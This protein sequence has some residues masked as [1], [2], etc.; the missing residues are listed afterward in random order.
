MAT[1]IGSKALI[2]NPALNP[3]TV[4]IGEWQTTGSHPYLPDTLLHGRVACEWLL[5]GAF[6]LMRSEIDEAHFPDGIAIFGSD[7][8]AKQLFLLTFDQR[9]VSRKYDVAIAGNQL[10]WWRDDP[11]FAQRVTLTIS[12]DGSTLVSMGE[13]SRDGAAWEGDLSQTYVRIAGKEHG[14]S[15][16]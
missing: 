8:A 13:M 11:R 4:L 12:E 1:S 7:D 14:R 3:L 2:P 9:G 15:N 10:T 5:G 16:E 6:V